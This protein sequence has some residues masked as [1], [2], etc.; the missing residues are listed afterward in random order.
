MSRGDLTHRGSDI[1]EMLCF[2]FLQAATHVN[3]IRYPTHTNIHMHG[4]ASPPAL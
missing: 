4:E 2:G 1:F 3:Y